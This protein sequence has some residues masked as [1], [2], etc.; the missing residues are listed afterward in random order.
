MDKTVALH[1]LRQKLEL[2]ES[3]GYKALSSQIGNIETWEVVDDSGKA[4]QIE[5]EIIWDSKPNG[6]IRL[7]GSIDDGGFRAFLPVSESR[8]VLQSSGQP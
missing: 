2:I 8:L 4:Y 1:L 6:I 7:L 5:I 3:T